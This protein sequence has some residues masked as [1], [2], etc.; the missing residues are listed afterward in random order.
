MK[1]VAATLQNKKGSMSRKIIQQNYIKT[2][3]ANISFS[4]R[5]GHLESL[6]ENNKGKLKQKEVKDMFCKVIVPVKTK[7]ADNCIFKGAF[8]IIKGE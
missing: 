6:K 5:M 1:Y 3:T 7:M 8:G 4:W 2:N